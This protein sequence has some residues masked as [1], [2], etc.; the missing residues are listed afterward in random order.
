M[1]SSMSATAVSLLVPL[2]FSKSLLR[3]QASVL[4]W[5]SVDIGENT[6]GSGIRVVIDNA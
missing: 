4:I 6:F 2:L 1:V 5:R 3:I